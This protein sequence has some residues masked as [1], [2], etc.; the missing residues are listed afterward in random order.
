[1]F[2]QSVIEHLKYYVYFL[3]DPINNEVFYIGKGTGNRV[4]NHVSC[5]L[6][7]DYLSDKIARIQAITSAGHQVEH[8]ILRH[9]LDEG[10]A[11]EVEAPM[12]DFIGMENLSNLQSGHYSGEFG[13]K[14]SDE[15]IA[16]Y[17]AT[18]LET[19]EP[20]LLININRLYHR[21]MNETEL[22]ESTRQAWVIG[23][24]RNNAK[25]AVATF[26][27]LT[28]E[29]YKIESWFEIKV[30]GKTRWG[31]NGQLADEPIRQSMR[32]KSISSYFL[33][34]A[35]NPIRYVNF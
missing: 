2:S 25:Y 22:Y 23:N 17:N 5:A 4:F 1:M 18:E 20:I 13:I 34:G 7:T 10:T 28:R 12:I 21:Q 8:F 30:K 29:V 32:Y 14:S 11:F 19:E 27:G 6:D 16:L 24:R 3:R 9:G 31:F 26:R 35:S 33:K 15:I